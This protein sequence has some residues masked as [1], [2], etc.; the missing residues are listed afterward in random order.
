MPNGMEQ[1]SRRV[2][3]AR[4]AGV[5]PPGPP[6]QNRKKKALCSWLQS[7]R[8][9]PR[10][11]NARTRAGDGQAPTEQ[12]RQPEEGESLSIPGSENLSGAERPVTYSGEVEGKKRGKD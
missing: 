6:H 8:R 4:R 3:K 7:G 10:G 2:G 5:T 1:D 11:C 9:L 12:R